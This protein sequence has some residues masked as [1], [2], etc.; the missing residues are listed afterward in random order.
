[1]KK[2]AKIIAIS[3]CLATT[4]FAVESDVESIEEGTSDSRAVLASVQNAI[5]ALQDLNP[6]MLQDLARQ[7]PGNIGLTT[8]CSSLCQT[9]TT[10]QEDA[11]NFSTGLSAFAEILVDLPD[12]EEEA[13]DPMAASFVAIFDLM[14]SAPSKLA[15]SDS[16]QDGNDASIEEEND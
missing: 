12:S 6:E 10:L 2:I 5:Q 11:D 3:L 7:K 15:R 1:M 8:L 9:L 16:Q 13:V 4:T 14:T